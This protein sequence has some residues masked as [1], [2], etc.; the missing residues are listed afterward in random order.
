MG[1]REFQKTVNGYLNGITKNDDESFIAT[2]Y[3]PFD[4]KT[5][6]LGFRIDAK[7][8]E[9]ETITL[10]KTDGSISAKRLHFDEDGM[11]RLSFIANTVIRHMKKRGFFKSSPQLPM[12]IQQKVNE[13]VRNYINTYNLVVFSMTYLIDKQGEIT[14]I[15]HNYQ[16]KIEKEKF[17]KKTKKKC[18]EPDC[19]CIINI[20]LGDPSLSQNV[21]KEVNVE[22]E[23]KPILIIQVETRDY[24]AIKIYEDVVGELSDSDTGKFGDIRLI[25]GRFLNWYD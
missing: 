1:R 8:F 14:I 5:Y 4:Q 12:K 15:P 11:D 22:N 25:E 18:N 24:F 17:Y 20:L 16:T 13:I 2:F 6:E 19:I 3:L 21:N 10:K 9:D 7:D 23:L